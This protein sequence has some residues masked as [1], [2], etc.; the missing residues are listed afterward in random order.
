MRIDKDGLPKI[1]VS[2][3]AEITG[4]SLT[5]ET[6][7]SEYAKQFF[8]EIYKLLMDMGICR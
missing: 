8:R 2:G 3:G 5:P 1:T 7:H 6:L 4:A